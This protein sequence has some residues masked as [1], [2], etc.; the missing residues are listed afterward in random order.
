MHTK[1]EKNYG[2]YMK[3]IKTISLFLA[4]VMLTA[5]FSACGNKNSDGESDTGELKG[6]YDI[7]MWVSEKDGVAEHFASQIDAFEKE[8]KGITIN[9]RI[10]GVTEA[11][12]GSKV[13]ADVATAPDIYCFAQ[14][15]LARLVQAA[16]LAPL[17]KS[18]AE[19]V[20][21]ENDE[22]SVSASSIGGTLYAY[23]LTS[24]NGYLMYYD[25]SIISDSDAD[26]MTKLIAACEKAGKKF[27]FSLENGWYTASF[28]FGVG[29]HSTWT[30]SADGKTFTSVDDDF[31]SDKGIIAMRGMRE[32]ATSSCYD[33]NADIFTDAAVVVTGIWNADAAAKHFGSNLGATDLPSFTVDGKSYHLGSFSGNKLLGVKPQAD[34]KRAAVLSLLAQYLTGEECQN[35]RFESLQWGPSNLKAQ[36]TD[37]VRANPTLTA[38]AEQNKYSVPQGQIHGSWWDISKVLGA[39]AKT[40]KTD[41]AIKKALANY[42]KAIK[43][44]V[45]SGS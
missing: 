17:G 18:A 14:D 3:I 9:A 36:S 4:S 33:N 29:C 39:E 11:D 34:N 20:R 1:N 45:S 41:D 23:P 42:E 22:G 37:A 12:T 35:Q 21:T 6:S 16:A 24:D 31:N 30:V 32:L 2:G 10:E 13:S 44:A 19:K 43:A 27:R 38:L 8:N 28:F 25:K 5:A 40:A 26:D 7:T 15:Q